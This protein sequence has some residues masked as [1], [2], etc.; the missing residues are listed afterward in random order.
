M[1]A[2]K[3]RGAAR[4]P[5]PRHAVDGPPISKGGAR[6]RRRA[7]EQRTAAPGGLTFQRPVLNDLVIVPVRANQHPEAAARLRRPVRWCA[8]PKRTLAQVA[9]GPVAES[10]AGATNHKGKQATS[11]FQRRVPTVYELDLFAA[12]Q[13]PPLRQ[14]RCASRAMHCL[15]KHAPAGASA[16]TAQTYWTLRAIE[17]RN[18]VVRRRSRPNADTLTL[19]QAPPSM[20]ACW[21]AGTWPAAERGRVQR[22]RSLALER[23]PCEL[24]KRRVWW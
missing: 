1:A 16:Q 18:A 6:S 9:C 20:R 21:R 13:G 11:I 15:Q 14:A 2:V 12:C 23:E 4:Q 5:R 3:H 24:D 10:C 8:T 7:A 19:T 22:V 17:R